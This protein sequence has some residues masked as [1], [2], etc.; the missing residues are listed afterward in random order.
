MK[1]IKFYLT[2]P[3]CGHS[4]WV[5][6]DK[7]EADGAFQCSNCGEFVFTENMNPIS[8]NKDTLV[9]SRKINFDK[10]FISLNGFGNPIQISI[11]NI[12]AFYPEGSENSGFSG[13]NIVTTSGRSF[14][15][16]DTYEDVKAL[17]DDSIKQ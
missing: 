12:E 11:E 3:S 8:S 15:V 1:T 6:R 13:T 16:H 17:I 14:M 2:C 7:A 10:R 9:E 4:D 5:Q